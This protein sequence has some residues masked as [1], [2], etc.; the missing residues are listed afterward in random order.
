MAGVNERYFKQVDTPRKAYWL[1]LLFADGWIVTHKDVSI[2]FALA[3]HER[4]LDLLEAFAFDLGCPS[5]VRRTRLGSPLHQVKVTSAEACADLA[6]HGVV[7]RKSSVI[8]LPDLPGHLMPHFVRG[9]F[10]GDGSVSVRGATLSAQITSGSEAMLE[11]VRA[12]LALAEGIQASIRQD[13]NSFVLR[14]YGG[15]AMRLA[16]FLYGRPPHGEIAMQRKQEKFFDYLGSGAGHSWEQLLSDL[17][18][19]PSR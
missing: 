11:Q 8:E 4:D 13:R 1:G 5:L 7:P 16:R 14:C 19:A 17:D 15:N 9:Y 10:D 3:L 6:C 18:S 2:G 12:Y